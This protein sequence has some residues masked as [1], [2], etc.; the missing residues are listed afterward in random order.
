MTDR[1]DMDAWAREQA[2]RGLAEMLA[3]HWNFARRNPGGYRA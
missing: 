3:D 2:R 1:A